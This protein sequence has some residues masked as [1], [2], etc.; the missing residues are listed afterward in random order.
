MKPDYLGKDRS[1]KRPNYLGRDTGVDWRD[2][3]KSTARRS[4]DRQQPG[5]GNKPGRPGDIKGPRWL[6][7]NK[8]SKDG[9]SGMF[10]K[11]EWLRKIVE[12]ALPRGLN[13]AIELRFDG[14]VAPVPTDWVMI[15]SIEF[16]S[17]LERA[18]ERVT[19]G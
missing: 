3:E 18:G 15:P 8:A 7:E 11:G 2:H 19:D 1:P 16:E 5:S 4:G 12:Q 10:V 13:P 6:R 14:Q 17:L 9:A